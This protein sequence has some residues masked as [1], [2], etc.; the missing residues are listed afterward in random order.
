MSGVAVT[1]FSGVFEGKTV[2][3]HVL[4]LKGSFYLWIGDEKGSLDSLC[5]S[6]KNPY[7]PTPISTTIVKGGGERLFGERLA[8]KLSTKTG[9]LCYVSCSLPS[10]SE[11]ALLQFAEG[12]IVEEIAVSPAAFGIEAH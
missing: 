2:Y 12:R 3:F 11:A 7:S 8:G 6:A 5:M 1:N 4:K 10:N 9:L